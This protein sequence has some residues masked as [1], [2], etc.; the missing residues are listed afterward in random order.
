MGGRRRLRSIEQTILKN[1]FQLPK[2]QTD[3]RNTP[4]PPQLPIKA[5]RFHEYKQM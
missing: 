5:D 4:Q 3:A 1:K 2:L